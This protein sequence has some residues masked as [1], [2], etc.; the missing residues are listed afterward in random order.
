MAELEGNA[1]PGLHEREGSMTRRMLQRVALGFGVG[2]M[3]ISVMVTDPDLA[4]AYPSGGVTMGSS[5]GTLG[6]TC[7]LRRDGTAACWGANNPYYGAQSLPPPGL[8]TELAAGDQHTCGLR[9]DGSVEY[10]GSSSD[11]RRRRLP[12]DCARM[13]QS[14]AGAAPTRDTVTTVRPGHR[15]AFSST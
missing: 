7:A 14:N 2:G 12:V 3:V 15:A 6:H 1:L 5:S 10:W 4:W 11:Q 9:P 8:F 13:V